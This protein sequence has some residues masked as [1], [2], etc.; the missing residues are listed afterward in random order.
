MQIN[1]PSERYTKNSD[2][3]IVGDTRQTQYI[4][5]LR[6]DESG[7]VDGCGDGWDQSDWSPLLP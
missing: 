4:P 5:E 2:I 3:A 7:E 6:E 1:K